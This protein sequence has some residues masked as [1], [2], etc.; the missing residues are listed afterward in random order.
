MSGAR[1][2]P[3]PGEKRGVR[4]RNVAVYRAVNCETPAD[5]EPCGSCS[6]CTGAGTHTVEIDAASNRGI[7]EI[8]DLREAAR[9]RP[10]RDKFKIWIL[11]E[12]HQITDAAF[13]EYG[14]N[15]DTISTMRPRF[16]PWRKALRAG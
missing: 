10:A 4:A 6:V 7:D 11:D 16:A 5:G 3:E 8:R 9:Y 1:E 13:T 15:A 14:V 12:A 2:N